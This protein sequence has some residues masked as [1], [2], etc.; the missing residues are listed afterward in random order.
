MNNFNDIRPDFRAKR[1]PVGGE[2]G[3]NSRRKPPWLKVRLPNTAAFQRVR[4]TLSRCGLHSICQEARCPNITEC[5]QDGTATF[6]IL[7]KVCTR[8]CL[9]CHVA[10]GVPAGVDP[11][12][13]RRLVAAARELRLKYVVV[14]SVTRDDLPDGGAS[15]F[16]ATIAALH[17][18]LPAVKVEVLI[19]DFQGD[20]RPSRRSSPPGR[21]INH[22]VEVAR[23]FST[24]ASPGKLPD[25]SRDS[26]PHRQGR[27]IRLQIGLHG[28]LRGEHGRH[29]AITGRSGRRGLPVR[30][31]RSVSAT[32]GQTLAGPEILSPRRVRRP[33]GG[34]PF[35]G[36]RPCRGGS[37]GPQFLPCRGGSGMTSASGR[38]PAL[39]PGQTAAT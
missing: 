5:F 16:A 18:H 29:S 6:L 30:D 39:R 1:T 9:Y 20:F 23:P 11:E 33:A 22:N 2:D 17:R 8:N 34:C 12:E 31:D 32:Y 28:R 36:L 10:H 14:T 25:L 24:F 37:P 19:P 21:V 3:G 15:H 38:R 26:E 27:I 7:G 4:H 13:P 35:Y